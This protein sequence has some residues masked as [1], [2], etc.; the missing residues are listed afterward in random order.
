MTVP[1]LDLQNSQ[2]SAMA[3]YLGVKRVLGP[4]FMAWEPETVWLELLDHKIDLPPVNRDKLMAV[5]TLLQTGAFYWDAAVFENT[6]MA[7]DHQWSAPEILQE[8]SPAQMVWA[9]LEANA[10][11][12]REGDAEGDF[13]YEPARYAAVSL[14]R[15]GFLLAPDMLEFAQEELDRLNQ[16]GAHAELRDRVKERWKGLDKN[17]LGDLELKETPEDVQI[18]YLASVHTYVAHRAEKLKE[19]LD[20]VTDSTSPLPAPH[21][22][23]ASPTP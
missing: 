10:I 13:D 3:L 20:A 18:G 16:N 9:V 7:F 14:H 12:D 17:T 23:L 15:A 5:V 8:A 1:P 6:T 19:E 22:L 4:T 11:R 2:I 21:P